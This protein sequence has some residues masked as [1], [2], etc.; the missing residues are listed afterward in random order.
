MCPGPGETAAAHTGASALRRTSV[1]A[2]QHTPVAAL[3]RTLGCTL[4][5]ALTLCT[6]AGCGGRGLYWPVIPPDVPAPRLV[7]PAADGSTIDLTRTQWLLVRLPDDPASGLR[8][9]YTIGK[10][11]ALYPSGDTPR[12]EPADAGSEASTVYTFRAEGVG[13]TSVKFVYH[14]PAQPSAAPAKSV[15]F[16]VVAR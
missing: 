8:W 11:R 15:A 3:R 7:G 10:D 13:I 9:S 5:A 14:D 16:D 12:R 4:L 6:L 2:S 1:T